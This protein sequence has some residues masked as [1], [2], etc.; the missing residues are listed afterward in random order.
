MD[1]RDKKPN[2]ILKSILIPFIL[3][4]LTIFLTHMGM[5]TQL[6]DQ[7]LDKLNSRNMAAQMQ[8][9]QNH[10]LTDEVRKPVKVLQYAVGSLFPGI[11]QG[12]ST[13]QEESSP[14]S[15]RLKSDL[16][17]DHVAFFDL[18]GKLLARKALSP[19]HEEENLTEFQGLIREGKVSREIFGFDKTAHGLVLKIVF[20]IYGSQKKTIGYISAIRSLDSHFF[21]KIHHPPNLDIMIFRGDQAIFSTIPA[22][23]G[24][25]FS[26]PPEIRKK[27]LQAHL[28]S[29]QSVERI[30][31]F[32]TQYYVISF[33][34][35]NFQGETV[36]TLMLVASL[37]AKEQSLK[38]IVSYLL[39]ASLIGMILL[40]SFGFLISKGITAPLEGLIQAT[41]RLSAGDLNTRAAIQSH[42][43]LITLS[44]A[45]NTMTENLQRTLISKNYFHTIIDTINDLLIIISP[46]QH[47]TFVNQA[48]LKVLGYEREELLGKPFHFLLEKN[49]S[50]REVDLNTE[51]QKGMIEDTSCDLITKAGESIPVSF[52]G[53][54]MLDEKKQVLEIV[55][56]ARDVREKAE[57]ERKIKEER[58]KLNTLIN[59]TNDLIF[60]RTPQGKTTFISHA[61]Q[62]ILGYSP[63]EFKN[64]PYELFL[65]SNPINQGFLESPGRWCAKGEKVEPY[66]TEFLARD[67]KR[68]FLEINE[69]PLLGK[70]GEIIQIMGI[71]RDIS[72]RKKLEEQV[73]DWQERQSKTTEETYQFGNIIGKS[74]KMQ[75]IY[76]LIKV[77]SQ[78]NSTVLVQGE[79]GTGKELIA[80][81]IHYQ[82]LRRD[83]PFI[84][85][86]CSV[87]SEQLLES[88]LFGHVK[89]AFTGAVS[90]KPGRFELADGGTIFLDEIGDVSLNE[91]V[92]LLRVVQEREIVRVGGNKRIK[93]NVRIIAATNKNLKEAV[94]RGTFREDLFYRLNVVP[95]IVPPLRERK[96]D[97]PLLV[98]HFIKKMNK[99]I[100]KQ[101]NGI[102][103]KALNILWKDDWPGNIRQL[104]NTI[105][106][107]V[108]R[109]RDPE[110]K[111][112]DLPAEI[113]DLEGE[114]ASSSVQ[115]LMADIERSA[116]IDVLENCQWNMTQAAL[117]LNI[118]RT[119]LWRKIKKYEVVKPDGLETALL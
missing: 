49:C 100:G 12:A 25:P 85:V 10:F 90:D 59:T 73:R 103:Q 47:I 107:A 113:H 56:I 6:V 115:D 86:T 75:E 60:I 66:W 77:V 72:E 64:L 22:R 79:S 39:A 95:V 108:I 102:S 28:E 116:L 62:D 119:T 17:L 89:G 68:L 83:H 1:K 11:L 41:H 24:E 109:C 9:I 52:S 97:I 105:E 30:F 74:R 78:N 104:E 53:W 21:R 19:L 33:P 76:E 4:F 117:K 3:V 13:D 81:A 20:P 118:S 58:D 29:P 91:Q 8:F 5:Q 114:S 50:L 35:Q 37:E 36:G 111:V 31:I 18:H 57:A 48:T 98:N 88:E 38:K 7:E 106:Y 99:K 54:P 2:K 93:I 23:A 32:D 26:I 92:K 101:I 71:G 16:S 61:V 70:K 80:Q 45:F 40:V 112:R 43:E 63:E 110:I 51:A 34:F 67:G 84:E 96:E 42:R 94:A 15:A 14:Q 46:D 55:G 27:V 65:S 69:A 82:S 87:L 44:Q